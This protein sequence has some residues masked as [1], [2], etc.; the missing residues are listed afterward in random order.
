MSTLE[1]TTTAIVHEAI[2]EEYEYIQYNKQLRLIRSVKDDM[3]QMQSIMNALRSTKQAYHW[4]ENQ[5]AKELLEEFPHMI[6]S[7]GKPR[8]EIPYENRKNLAPGLK[9]YYVHRLLVNA[10]AMWASPRYA[11]YIFMMLDEL[12]KAER[13]EMEKKLQAK[14]EVIE[15]KDKSIQKRIPRSVP[16]GKEKSY[17]YMIYTEE[18]EKEE[19]RD[20][21]MLHL[22]RRNNKSFY[23]LAKIYKS[24][25]NWFYRENLPIS[26][27]P[28]EQIKEIVKN[29][30][31]QTH[32]DIKGCT[33]LTF[34]EDLTLLKEKI[35]EYF[36][37]FKE[38]E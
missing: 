34:K 22:V 19:D 18:L 26:M 25:R 32:Y 24:D 37:N 30:L 1:N 6:A 3:Y 9:G 38:E 20:M 11:C 2:N 4:F 8:E 5:Q 10:V 16:K 7:L 23:D 12:Y 36:D 21:V 15:S 31:P 33:I 28:N 13:G 14:D 27:T 29:T 17:K 35:T